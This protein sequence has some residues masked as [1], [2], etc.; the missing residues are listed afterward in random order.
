MRRCPVERGGQPRATEELSRFPFV[1]VP[2]TG[3]LGEVGPEP[4]AL[5]VLLEPVREPRPFA[6]QRLVRHLHPSVAL[7]EE[8]VLREPGEDGR[9]RRRRA[10]ARTRSSGPSGGRASRRRRSRPSRSSTRRAACCST[11]ESCSNE[12]SASRATAPRTPPVRSYASSVSHPRSRAAHSSTRAVESSGRPPGLL[13]HVRDQGVGKGRLDMHPRAPGG[14]LDRLG[15]AP[16]GS[17]GRAA[18]GSR[19][20]ARRTRD[21]RRGVA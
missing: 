19:R 9:R 18:H 5:K 2:L 14:E 11:S 10:R 17:S 21:G 15:A 6:D 13:L 3:R 8:P 12:R 20:T 7:G 16:P 1:L 4:V